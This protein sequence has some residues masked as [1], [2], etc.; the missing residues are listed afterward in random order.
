MVIVLGFFLIKVTPKVSSRLAI[1]PAP[2]RVSRARRVRKESRKSPRGRA[3]KVSKECSPESQK[4]PKRV[5]KS[6]FGLFSDS[7]GT[8]GRT[9]S[10]L[11]GPCPRVLFRDSFRT[12][13]VSWARRARET[14]CGAGPIAIL[15]PKSDLN[16]LLGGQKVTLNSLLGLLRGRP[17]KSLLS[18]I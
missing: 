1:G 9:L 18:Y 5:Q 15:D 14:L 17:R 2:H 7:F 13:P 4:S 11:L 10:G 3:P 8:P 6:G 12:L 16:W